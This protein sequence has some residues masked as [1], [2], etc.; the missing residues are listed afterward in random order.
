MWTMSLV[1]EASANS[2]GRLVGSLLGVCLTN[3]QVPEAST[4]ANRVRLA[5]TYL[6]DPA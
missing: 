5:I 2:T 3:L 6:H 4:L 1:H